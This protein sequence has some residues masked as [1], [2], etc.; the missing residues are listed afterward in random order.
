M[1]PTATRYAARILL[2]QIT[3]DE[4][5]EI[6]QSSTQYLVERFLATFGLMNA[7][8]DPTELVVHLMR[9]VEGR[10]RRGMTG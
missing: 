6:W 1:K 8:T 3:I 9:Q 5:P 4:V 2:R 7:P 10:A